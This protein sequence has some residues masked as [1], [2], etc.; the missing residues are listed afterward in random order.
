MIDIDNLFEQYFKKYI[1]ENL[2]KMTEE[3]IEDKIP[4][5]YTEFG[6]TPNEKLGGK[7]P[8][9]YFKGFSDDE[10][11]GHFKNS[12]QKNGEASS[13]LC[14]E[15]EN[16]GGLNDKLCNLIS[17]ENGDE[18]STYAVNM[19]GND[20]DVKYLEHF[21][22]II[23]DNRAGESLTEAL[24]ELLRD[25]GDKV[26]EK[27]LN[28]YSNDVFG[29]E[30]LIEILSRT[31]QDDRVFEILLNELKSDERNIALN[32]GYIAR[33]GDERAIKELENLIEKDGLSYYDFK[34]LKNAIEELG[35]EYSGEYKG[36]KFT[37][38]KQS[39]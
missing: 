5:L 17:V 28:I 23:T 26:K 4:E 9:E 2:G 1:A 37:A 29:K 3:E 18:L 10:L 12:V 24:T 36:S 21:V 15:I 13:F 38:T 8:R 16:R 25:N 31:S 34:E 33:Y 35:G 30:N 32:A 6:N 11:I 14:D 19:L 27:I 22:D 20:I 39:H 7:T